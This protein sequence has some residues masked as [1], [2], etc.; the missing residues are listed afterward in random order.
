MT[1][2]ISTWESLLSL[3][4]TISGGSLKLTDGIGLTDGALS[5]K[6]EDF[7]T[8]LQIENHQKFAVGSDFIE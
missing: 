6:F 1:G 5:S 8:L 4:A 7:A 2:E 3:S